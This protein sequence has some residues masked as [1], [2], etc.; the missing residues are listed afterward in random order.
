VEVI[1]TGA[2]HRLRPWPG[3]A[4]AAGFESLWLYDHFQVD[5]LG[6]AS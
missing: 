2:H 1:R 4:E 6:E 3:R 5:P